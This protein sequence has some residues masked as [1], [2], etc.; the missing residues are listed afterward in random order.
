MPCLA[1]SLVGGT[2]HFS[3]PPPTLAGTSLHTDDRAGSV[4]TA[5][6]APVTT[7]AIRGEFT[8]S[9]KVQPRSLRRG[10]GACR[11]TKEAAS[12]ST[13]T[14]WLKGSDKAATASC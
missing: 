9:K 6:A 10:G 8:Q 14:P 4:L 2:C 5:R 7:L 13:Y 1:A 12:S 3:L 11:S